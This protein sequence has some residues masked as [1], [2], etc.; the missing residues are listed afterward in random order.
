MVQKGLQTVD[1]DDEPVDGLIGGWLSSLV[2][3]LVGDGELSLPE[4]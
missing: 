2:I 4:E 1:C 3:E